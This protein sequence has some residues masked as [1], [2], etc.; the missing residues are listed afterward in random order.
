M[1]ITDGAEAAETLRILSQLG[2]MQL[3]LEAMGPKGPD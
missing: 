2:A 3:A 1:S